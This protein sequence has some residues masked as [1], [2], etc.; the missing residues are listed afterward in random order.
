MK[1]SNREE[2]GVKLAGRLREFFEGPVD[3]I[4]LAI[5]RSGVVVGDA[6]AR[7]MNLPLDVLI[8]KRI[9]VPGAPDYTLGAVDRD[10]HY[11]INPAAVN[12]VD[13]FT[14]EAERL[15]NIRAAEQER[16]FISENSPL[17]DLR[18]K[19]VI[20]VDDGAQSGSTALMAVEILKNRN[21]RQ[22]V[23]ALPVCSPEAMV[24]LH[25]LVDALIVDTVPAMFHS[26]ADWY[27]DFLPEEDEKVRSILETHFTPL[28]VKR[29]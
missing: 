19:C 25:G 5:T 26:L 1:Y 2:A 7:E 12:F 11:L 17:P 9:N 6:I 22:I 27:F 24:Y 15:K 28:P 23:L 13:R 16:S 4:V 10:G 20:L 21:P 18:D 3:G 14:F 8:V 29:D